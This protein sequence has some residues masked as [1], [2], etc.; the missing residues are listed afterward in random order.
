MGTNYHSQSN[1]PPPRA[2]VVFAWYRGSGALPQGGPLFSTVGV[3]K[4]GNARRQICGIAVVRQLVAM[5]Q[6]NREEKSD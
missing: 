1:L 4:F 5:A 6:K 3:G 2:N